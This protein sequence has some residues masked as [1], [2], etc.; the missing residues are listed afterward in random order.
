MW[1]DAS[2]GYALCMLGVID[3]YA[4]GIRYMSAMSASNDTQARGDH[5]NAGILTAP[6]WVQESGAPFWVQSM[7]GSIAVVSACGAPF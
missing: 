4:A 2:V 1:V 7:R 3:G 6:I 5:T